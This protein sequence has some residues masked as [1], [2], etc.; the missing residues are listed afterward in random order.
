MLDPSNLAFGRA[1]LLF[2]ALLGALSLYLGAIDGTQP[3]EA[4]FWLAL[5]L[6]MACYG[7]IQLGALPRLQPVWLVL[8]LAA[9]VVAV[10]L[11]LLGAAT[12]G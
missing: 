4:I 5:A 1:L 11:A 3:H 12:A 10:C 2:A 9:G 8:G 7:L 6:F